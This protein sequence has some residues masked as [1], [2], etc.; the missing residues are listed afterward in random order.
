MT[1]ALQGRPPRAARVG[2]AAEGE[3][4]APFSPEGPL[5][6]GAAACGLGGAWVPGIGAGSCYLRSRDVQG[7]EKWSA[8]LP[9]EDL[10]G[11]AYWSR[12][13]GLK[14]P[15]G[16]GWGGGGILDARKSAVAPYTRPGLG[17]YFI[18]VIIIEPT[19]WVA[20]SLEIGKGRQGFS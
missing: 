9:G 10:R 3:P 16:R 1:G 11:I 6:P 14:R 5:P 2:T 15:P 20:L 8:R 13:S 7:R 4:A 19:K 18:I 17:G 12:G